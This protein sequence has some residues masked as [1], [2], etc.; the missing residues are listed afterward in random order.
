MKDGDIAEILMFTWHCGVVI[1]RVVFTWG[2]SN[3]PDQTSNHMKASPR[4]GQYGPF[5]RIVAT[6]W[7]QVSWSQ[8]GFWLHAKIIWSDHLQDDKMDGLSYCLHKDIFPSWLQ[9][10]SCKKKYSLSSAKLIILTITW[11]TKYKKRPE[12]QGCH[13]ILSPPHPEQFIKLRKTKLADMQ[14]LYKMG[15]PN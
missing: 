12:C 5:T 2:G 14:F 10:S 8:V 6:G 4:S 15:H 13:M 3:N 11:S 1:I 7:L 9:L